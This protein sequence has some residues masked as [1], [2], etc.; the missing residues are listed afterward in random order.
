MKKRVILAVIFAGIIIYMVSAFFLE[1]HPGKGDVAPTFV[2][3][4]VSG[5]NFSFGSFDG[6]VTFL[7]FWATWCPYCVEELPSIIHLNDRFKPEGLKVV[8]VLFGCEDFESDIEE[9]IKLTSNLF[10]LLVD[11][12]CALSEEYNVH[13]IPAVFI[14]GPDGKIIERFA[15]VDWNSKTEY[16]AGILNK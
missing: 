3:K 1:V 14:I 4:D 9:A 15:D 7:H 8:S 11:T 16:I 10:P 6:E 5:N 2:L 12:D 13:Y